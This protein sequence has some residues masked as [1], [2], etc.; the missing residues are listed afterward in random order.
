[1]GDCPDYP[2]ACDAKDRN[3]DLKNLHLDTSSSHIRIFLTR[4]KKVI[5]AQYPALKRKALNFP[6]LS[7]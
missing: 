6:R 3:V 2:A 7:Q 1:M 4:E 5:S